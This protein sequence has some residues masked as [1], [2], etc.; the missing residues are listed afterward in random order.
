[1][2]QEPLCELLILGLGN[3]LCSDDGVGVVAVH[4]LARG[5]RLPAGVRALD[6]G[7]LGLSL[8]PHLQASRRVIL[9]DAVAAQGAPGSLVRLDGADVAT[10]VAGRLSVHQIGVADLLEGARLLDQGP[11]VLR[12]LGVVP[13]STALG[14]ELTPNVALAVDALV[15]MAVREARGLGFELP[16]KSEADGDGA[17]DE[18]RGDGPGDQVDR[19]FGITLGMPPV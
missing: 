9:L 12:L 2:K 4:R 16:A 11:E 1:M 18:E 14:I 19:A 15:A 17:C 8:L 7:T 10:A 6:G 5:H 3:L 13:A